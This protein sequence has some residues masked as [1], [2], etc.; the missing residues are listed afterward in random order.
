LELFLSSWHPACS[1]YIIIIIGGNKKVAHFGRLSL[2][3]KMLGGISHEH[4]DD[5]DT[6]GCLD[7]FGVD[8]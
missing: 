4:E 2:S 1:E 8:E 3:I 7:I 5:T 6:N